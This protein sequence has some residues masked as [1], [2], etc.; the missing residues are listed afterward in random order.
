[1]R[2]DLINGVFKQIR[3]YWDAETCGK[4]GGS[5]PIFRI[6][7]FEKAELLGSEGGDIKPPQNFSITVYQLT[8]CNTKEIP[9]FQ[10]CNFLT[11]HAPI[12]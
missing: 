5:A 12:Q 3:L 11:K 2:Y 4:L 6:R 9:N 8:W 10:T 7:Q 1:M